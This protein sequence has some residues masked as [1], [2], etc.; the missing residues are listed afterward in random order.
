M[1]RRLTLDDHKW[2][3]G[4]KDQSERSRRSEC[5]QS[6]A[7]W[8]GIEEIRDRGDLSHKIRSGLIC[9]ETLAYDDRLGAPDVHRGAKYGAQIVNRRARR[10]C[11][12]EE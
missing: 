6:T 4:R 11:D 5:R 1:G 10:P 9:P 7:R 3:Y 2:Y 8:V 12:P